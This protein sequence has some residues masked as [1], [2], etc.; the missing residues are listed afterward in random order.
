MPLSRANDC[1]GELVARQPGLAA[2]QV[3]F[4][5]LG[6]PCDHTRRNALEAL[7]EAL[8]RGAGR[9]P[10]TDGGDAHAL[11]P[12]YAALLARHILPCL[13][14][15]S[16]PARAAAAA[17]LGWLSPACVLPPLMRLCAARDARTRSAAA[18]ALTAVLRPHAPPPRALAALLRCLTHPAAAEG[19]DGDGEGEGEAEQG[20]DTAVERAICCLGKWAADDVAPSAWPPLIDQLAGAMAAHPE[21]AALVRCASALGPGMGALGGPGAHV[22]RRVHASLAAQPE[23]PPGAGEVFARLQP[24]LLMRVLPVELFSEASSEGVLYDGGGGGAE[25]GSHACVADTLMRRMCDAREATDVRRLSA[26]L[27][28]RLRPLAAWPPLLA[29]LLEA[30]RTADWTCLR[31]CLFAVCAALSARGADAVPG[32]LPPRSLL[33][34][35]TSVLVHHSDGASAEAEEEVMKTQMGCIDCLSFLCAAQLGSAPAPAVRIVELGGDA[36]DGAPEDGVADVLAPLLEVVTCATDAPPWHAGAVPPAMLPTLRACC[37]NVVISVS[38]R[39]EG[40]ARGTLARRV[41]PVV[42]AGLARGAMPPAARAGAYQLLFVVAHHAGAQCA[43]FAAD[44]AELAARTLRSSAA[45]QP[46]TRIAAAK[47]LTALLGGEAAVTQALAGSLRAVAEAVRDV[48]RL[49]ACAEL[50][51]VCET[52]ARALGESV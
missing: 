13:S 28:G 10:A 27:Y 32:G 34:A 47:L 42:A 25:F 39:T 5:K 33:A 7:A 6:A 29:R 31:A 50:R 4:E 30:A 3:V 52:L 24:L 14:D 51:G 43:P 46:D 8:A 1:Q 26:E 18:L 41:L 20:G 22:L 40:L 16:L 19:A 45:E 35:L 48:A 23:A 44:L 11:Q 9:A 38:K 49:D 37:A 2:L 15:A 36:G 12:G 21:H 17:L